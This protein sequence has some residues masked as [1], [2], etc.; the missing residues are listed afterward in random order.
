MGVGLL[1]NFLVIVFN[2]G[3]MPIS[4]ETVRQILP[5]SADDL[6]MVGRRLGLS[7]D[8]IYASN[9]IC[10]PWLSDRFTL[11]EWIGYKVAFSF[12]DI[13][14]AIGALGLLW[15]LSNPDNRRQNEPD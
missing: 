1:A 10:L 3:W 11:P 12:G 7:K 5:T 8:W 13:L 4:P 15:S 6:P 9:D 14:M 2:G